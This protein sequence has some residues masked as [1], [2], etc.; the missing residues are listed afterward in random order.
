MVSITNLL[1]TIN[2]LINSDQPC[3]SRKSFRDA[4]PLL[5]S[6]L[7]LVDVNIISKSIKVATEHQGSVHERAWV[8]K[9]SFFS[10]LHL[11]DVE[12]EASIE[13]QESEGTLTSKD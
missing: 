5:L 2:S 7:V 3:S 9:L 4:D 10:D 13:D 11:F 1:Y 6:N 8:Y 12:Y